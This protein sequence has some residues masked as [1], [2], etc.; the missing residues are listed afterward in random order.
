MA[1]APMLSAPRGDANFR[2]IVGAGG[3]KGRGERLAGAVAAKP[4]TAPFR[5]REALDSRREHNPPRGDTEMMNTA[6]LK[7][8]L[9]ATLMSHGATFA[10]TTCDQFGSLPALSGTYI[11]QNNFY[12]PG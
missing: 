9:M 11:V 10:Q 4:A 6:K 5:R 1:F 2:A 12:N 7:L 8:A 3:R